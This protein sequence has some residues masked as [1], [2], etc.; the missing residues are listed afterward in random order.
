MCAGCSV[1][2]ALQTEHVASLPSCSCTGTARLMHR[3]S[4]IAR[5]LLVVYSGVE[6][7]GGRCPASAWSLPVSHCGIIQCHS[8]PSAAIPRPCTAHTTPIVRYEN[9][10]PTQAGEDVYRMLTKPLTVPC[11]FHVILGTQQ[12]HNSST[13]R[14]YGKIMYVYH[15]SAVYSCRV[16]IVCSSSITTAAGMHI[17]PSASGDL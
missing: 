17:V 5:L 1:E 15:I 7:S 9:F 13:G 12:R 11:F 16:C 8:L 14:T 6:V 3:V 2:T 4:A 10:T